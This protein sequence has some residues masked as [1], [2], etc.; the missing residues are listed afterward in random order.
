MTRKNKPK[1]YKVDRREFLTIT[2]TSSKFIGDY[3]ETKGV[4]LL[5]VK[6]ELNQ[7]EEGSSKIPVK[8]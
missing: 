5:V 6:G 1:V 4:H 2:H 7:Q 3:R 8:V